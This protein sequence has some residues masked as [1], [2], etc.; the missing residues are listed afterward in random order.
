M[1]VCSGCLSLPICLT[2]NLRALFV[3]L[4]VCQSVSLVRLSVVPSHQLMYFICLRRRGKAVVWP[5]KTGP[6]AS[7]T[8]LWCVG[9]GVLGEVG[10][11]EGNRKTHIKLRRF[12]TNSTI[13]HSSL[14]VVFVRQRLTANA[15][16]SNRW[17]WKILNQ[18]PKIHRWILYLPPCLATHRS[19]GGYSK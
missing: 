16:Q 17:K 5:L 13:Q 8:S 6:P 12:L 9:R 11:W 19:L 15:G 14:F 7:S 4:I 1:S 10:E 3:C 18:P 2:L